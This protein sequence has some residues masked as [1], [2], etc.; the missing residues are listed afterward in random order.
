MASTLT[1]VV[2]GLGSGAKSV[3]RSSGVGNPGMMFYKLAFGN[4]Y[5]VGGEDLAA[6][7]NDFHEV[8]AIVVQQVDATPADNRNY[9]VNLT[10]K[11]LLMLTAIGTESGAVDQSAAAD[12]RLTVFGRLK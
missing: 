4:P 12:V 6:I 7:W 10:A 1:K 9:L 3:V 11:K 2:T 5:A 8:H